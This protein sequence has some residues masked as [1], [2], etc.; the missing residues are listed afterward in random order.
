[1]HACFRQLANKIGTSINKYLE[2]DVKI[3]I[4]VLIILDDSKF[5]TDL[6]KFIITRTCMKQ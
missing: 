4:P 1:M 3:S 6:Y 2:F 5:I